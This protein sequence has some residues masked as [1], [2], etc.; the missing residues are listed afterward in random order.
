MANLHILLCILVIMRGAM[1]DADM[2]F[3]NLCSA[4]IDGADLKDIVSVLGVSLSLDVYDMS[5]IKIET[6]GCTPDGYC[7]V[8]TQGLKEFK[9]K[10][11]GP[12]GAVFSPSEH[13]ANLNTSPNS[14]DGHFKFEFV[15][16]GIG[17]K[18]VLQSASD[19]NDGI[20]KPFRCDNDQVCQIDIDLISKASHEVISKSKTDKNG[21]FKFENVIPGKYTI[22]ANPKNGYSFS[23]GEFDCEI[24]PG[25][26]QDCN[27]QNLKI[28]GFAVSGKAVSYDE[29]LADVTVKIFNKA[30]KELGSTVTNSKGEYKFTNIPSGVYTLR[31]SI[32]DTK[33]K[34]KIEQ[35][36]LTIEVNDDITV[37]SQ[38]FM[39][40][41]FSIT[42]KVLNTKDTGVADVV[43]K[44]DGQRKAVTNDN[45][46]YKLDEIVPGKYI[47]EGVHDDMIFEPMEIN[48]TPQ[49]KV[50]PDL[51]VSEYKVCGHLI[52]HNDEDS[53]R[54]KKNRRVIFKDK[55]SHQDI[56]VNA[57]DET[58]EFCVEIKP[59][60]YVIEP[61][62]SA[63]EQELGLKFKPKSISLLVI[64]SPIK[65]LKFEQVQYSAAGKVQC[66]GKGNCAGAEIKVENEKSGYSQTIIYDGNDYNITN[67]LPG[68]Y[69]VKISKPGF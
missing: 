37:V 19:K 47:L 35:P 10:V 15:G 8:Q 33:V 45:G 46:V 16:F 4:Q 64:N 38:A 53:Q 69:T 67:I 63:E 51:V 32:D 17:S 48:I 29:D 13:H 1:C 6:G 61:F 57:N 62:I 56:I 55:Q 60:K 41:G 2:A 49:S 31:A 36:T 34:F 43:I 21:A 68:K 22:R 50:V 58:G 7:L 26:D 3:T 24:K 27:S 5:G 20:N 11:S 40:T 66:R 25:T 30:N 12:S 9:L 23:V 65:K 39:A 44:I 54:F 52:F 28:S 42:G 59:Q 14:C 18:V